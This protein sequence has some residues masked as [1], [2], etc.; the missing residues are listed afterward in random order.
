VQNQYS[1]KALVKGKALE[2]ANKNDFKASDGWCSNFLNRW[3]LTTRSPTKQ[4]V[5]NTTTIEERNEKIRKFW[6]TI[7]QVR[8][9]Q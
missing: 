2:L 5:K 8:G 4:R 1:L 7:I 3:D 6:Q 9:I